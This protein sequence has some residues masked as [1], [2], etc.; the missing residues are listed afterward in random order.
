V[1]ELVRSDD[2]DAAEV[3]YRENKKHDCIRDSLALDDFGQIVIN[4]TFSE[5]EVLALAHRTFDQMEEWIRGYCDI[6]RSSRHPRLRIKPEPFRRGLQLLGARFERLGVRMSKRSVIDLIASNAVWRDDPGV[7]IRELIQNSVEACR[8]RAHHSSRADAYQPYVRVVF[9]RTGRTVSIRDNGCGMSENTVLNNLLTVGNS[10][11]KERAYTQGDYAPIARFGVGFW[12]VFT[13]AERATIE[14]SELEANRD[15]VANR[16]ARGIKFEVELGELKDYTVFRGNQGP[17]GT[18]IVL[19]LKEGVVLDEVFERARGHLLSTEVDLTLVLDDEETR[20]ESLV[21]E[22]TDET[23]LGAR[24]R[25]LRASKLEIFRWRHEQFGVDLAMGL[26][27]RIEGGKLTFRQNQSQ[28]VISSLTSFHG[29]RTAVCG[30]VVP[31][32]RGRMAFALERV[33]AA[34]A[35]AHSP[36]GFEYSLDRRALERNAAM[37]RFEEATVD[38]VHDGYREFLKSRNAYTPRE[39]YRLAAESELSGGNV[40]DTYTGPELKQANDRWADLLCFCLL[41]VKDAGGDHA[42]YLSLE[43]LRSTAGHC[44]VI[45]NRVEVPQANG[46][47]NILYPEHAHKLT[48]QLLRER[49]SSELQPGENFVLEANRQASMLFDADPQ[50]TVLMIRRPPAFSSGWI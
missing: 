29:V 8:Y 43:Q 44:W 30:F 18:L 28:S 2:S 17:V 19:H 1:L 38:L 47:L 23:L 37:Q 36:K 35:N 49:F 26:A 12:S 46:R 25:A 20:V 10:R 33:G 32:V 9:D 11:S 41:P 45:Q 27:H 15:V 34:H 13:I 4:G 24:A 3:S 22:V 21:P 14:T 7:S 16:S 5:P 48:L 42:K 31:M 50:S 39:I 40:Y 6:D